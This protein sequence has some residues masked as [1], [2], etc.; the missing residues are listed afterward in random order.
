MPI[1]KILPLVL[2]SEPLSTKFA[3]GVEVPMPTKPLLFALLMM[4]DGEELP[5]THETNCG[6]VDAAVPGP[7]EGDPMGLRRRCR[8]SYQ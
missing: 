1:W 7:M 5:A 8:G 6:E 4:N 2:T 3:Y